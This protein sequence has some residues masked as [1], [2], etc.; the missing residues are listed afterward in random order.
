ETSK[1]TIDRDGISRIAEMIMELSNSTRNLAK[2]SKNSIKEVE[3]VATSTV[4]VT[5]K[6]TKG[7]NSV[8]E[9]LNVINQ[10]IT[11]SSENTEKLSNISNTVHS[12]VEQLYGG[13]KMLEKS[14]NN[15]RA[16]IQ[17]FSEVFSKL[18]L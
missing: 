18:K 1:E 16:E 17:K 4:L 11:S 2:E 3:K 14:I 10:V 12:A 5:E 15:I 6:I 13:I 9:S 7:L 8:R